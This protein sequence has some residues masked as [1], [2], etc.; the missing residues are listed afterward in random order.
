MPPAP[1]AAAP[2]SAAADPLIQLHVNGAGVEVPDDGSSLLDVLRDRLG[3]H[4][5]KDGCSPQG[6]CGCCTVW[7]T[8][9]TRVACVTPV[10]RLQGR[11]VTTLESL[12]GD[13]AAEWAEALVAT[14]GSQCGFC[15]P[16]IVMRLAALAPEPAGRGHGSAAATAASEKV[17][18]AL[19]AHVC[20]CT[21]WQTI[22]E[23]ASLVYHGHRG[24]T[25]VTVDR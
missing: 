3:L 16:G 4:S 18:Q 20:R 25:P 5:V 17:G 13:G 1:A 12:P 15:T 6:Q 2:P 8:H 19:V 24:R 11:R 21:G 7:V 22:E 14:G 23:A 9:A 10:R